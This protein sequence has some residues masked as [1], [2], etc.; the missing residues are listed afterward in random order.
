MSANLVLSGLGLG[1]VRRWAYRSESPM[2][3]KIGPP[4]L[5]WSEVVSHSQR[6]CLPFYKPADRVVIRSHPQPFEPTL[7]CSRTE[8]ADDKIETLV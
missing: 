8:F 6:K 7:A 3:G 1:Q 5:R 2:F 4:Y